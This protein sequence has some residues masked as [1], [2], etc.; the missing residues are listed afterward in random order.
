MA[1][2]QPRGHRVGVHASSGKGDEQLGDDVVGGRVWL[3]RIRRGQR[4]VV[5]AS[6]LGRPS[7]ERLAGQIAE[8][9]GPLRRAKGAAME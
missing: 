3:V 7:A 5:V 6:E 9:I 2:S 4:E 8:L 1:G